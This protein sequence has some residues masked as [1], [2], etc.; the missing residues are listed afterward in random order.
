M[1]CSFSNDYQSSYMAVE[2][3]Y[4]APNSTP[5]TRSLL[6]LHAQFDAIAIKKLI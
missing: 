4:S 5:P 3:I 6:Q 2:H 1:R